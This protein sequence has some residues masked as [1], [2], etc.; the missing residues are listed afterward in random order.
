MFGGDDFHPTS[1]HSRSPSGAAS[2]RSAFALVLLSLLG[3]LFL[4]GVIYLAFWMGGIGTSVENWG[5]FSGSPKSEWLDDGNKMKLLEDFTYK[6]RRKKPWMAPRESIVDGASIP[7]ILWTMVGAPLNGEYRNASIVHDVECDLKREESDAV[8]LMFYEGCRCGGV[9]ETKAKLLY[10]AVYYFGPQWTVASERKVV[11]AQG[12]VVVERT[13]RTE[14]P[15]ARMKHGTRAGSDPQP[16]DAE[17]LA[18]LEKYINKHNPT[19]EQIKSLDLETL[20][21]T[22]RKQQ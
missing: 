21:S 8:H 22:E 12:K 2:P 19:I 7:R 5:E 13:V 17:L 10:A 1:T 20:P 15:R 16:S 14:L 11:D 3:G 9:G 18:R 4:L 6:D